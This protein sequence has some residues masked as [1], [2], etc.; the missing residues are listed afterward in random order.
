MLS[1]LRM[2]VSQQPLVSAAHGPVAPESSAGHVAVHFASSKAVRLRG[3]RYG[4]GITSKWITDG[5]GVARAAGA[6]LGMDVRGV[7]PRGRPV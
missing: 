6:W 4:N 7:P 3:S 2:P 5:A 1:I